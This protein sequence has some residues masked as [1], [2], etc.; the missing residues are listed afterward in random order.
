M[1]VI[2]ADQYVMHVPEAATIG[3][4][5]GRSTTLKIA[6]GAVAPTVEIEFTIHQTDFDRQFS[7]ATIDG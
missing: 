7:T 6:G 2:V 3:Q 4:T 1:Y 5:R